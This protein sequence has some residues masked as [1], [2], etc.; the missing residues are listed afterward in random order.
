M[1]FLLMA[2]WAF[3][4]NDPGG[5]R[6]SD[7][8]AIHR[9]NVQRLKVAWTFHTGDIY[10]AQG[11]NGTA[12]EATPLF[13]DNTLYFA[14]PFGRV[15]ALE[16]DTGRQIW[17]FDPKIKVGAGYGDFANRGV[18]TWVDP[19]KKAGDPCRRRI[20]LATVD[21][22]LFALDA[23]T[24]KTCSDF[25]AIDLRKDIRNKPF[26][27]AEYEETSPP[28]VIGDT[29]VVGSAVADNNRTDAASGEIRAFDARTGKKRWTFDPVPQDDGDPGYKTWRGPKAHRTGAANAWSVLSADP[30]RDLVFVPTGSASPDYYGGERLGS[31]LYA[32][33]VIA[34]RA[35]TGK[36]VWHFQ[37]IHHDL[38]DYDV[39]SQPVLIDYKGKPA[40]AV[41]SKSGS[42]FVLDRETGVPLVPVQERPVPK[43]TI[44]GEEASPT[45]PF[46]AWILAPQKLRAEDA[47]GA[48]E[49]DKTWCRE[50]IAAARNEGVFTPP[51]FEGTLVF[52]GNIGGL[53]WGAV[54][55]DPK[56][57]LLIVPTN[58]VPA[59]VK[60]VPRDQAK[61]RREYAGWEWGSQRGTP[62]VMLR[63][64]LLSP[65]GTPCS[66][67]P[68]GALTAID[69]ATGERKWE[70]PLGGETGRINLG[71]P[72]VTAGGLVFIGATIDAY[73]RAYDVA[74]GREVWKSPLPASARATPMTFQS[75]A[76]KQ[77]VVI[78]AGGHGVDG[79]K[80]SD[81]LLAFA[82]E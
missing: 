59:L 8:A 6:Y 45:Q 12:F 19:S 65:G 25:A 11:R 67:P 75:A 35:S 31:N 33:S 32:N 57:K 43:S 44:P 82:V 53:H 58:R 13:V 78:A 21:A 69:L 10:E 39:A 55:Y 30:Q 64:F 77:Y 52:P 71:G 49:A 14:T 62:Y 37:T 47:W 18:S 3:Y 5:S 36:R 41:G 2:E 23:A 17:A 63:K 29:V 42:L 60:L 46:S 7:L 34:L 4:G 81:A 66:P 70:V 40:V 22:R 48:S 28:L 15:I 27:L 56:Q 24:G 51:S 16:P 79:G 68:F 26:E 50:Q 61:P 20:F 9:D 72:L 1:L 54:A 76:G 73:I 74:T 38:W 80:R